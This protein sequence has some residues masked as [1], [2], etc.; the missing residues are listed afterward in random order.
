MIYL[1]HNSTTPLD[2]RVLDAMLPYLKGK[3]GNAASREHA[4][5]WDARD[6]VEDARGQVAALLNAKPNEIVFTSGATESIHIA[7][8]GLFLGPPSPGAPASHASPTS[9]GFDSSRPAPASPDRSG[10]LAS[11]ADCLGILA[12]AVEHEAVL[13]A[14][15][16]LARRGTRVEM[17]GVD[18]EGRIDP[19]AIATALSA[20]P[21]R[22]ICLMAANNETGVLTPLRACA[23]L[24]HAQGGLLFTDAA[25][26][27]GKI[28]LD[29]ER[30]GFD[31]AGVSAHKLNGPKG[32]GAL[33]VRNGGNGADV[34][35]G[36]NGGNGGT[37]SSLYPLLAAG[38]Q[39][40]GLR[41]GTANVP[42][43]VGFGEACRL[44][45][46]EMEARMEA[47]RALRDRL[48]TRIRERV[49]GAR[50]NGGGADRLG[51]TAN[52]VF[53]GVDARILIRD[54]HDVAVSTRSACSSGAS[55]PSHVLKAMGLADAD[56]YASVR[57]SLGADTTLHDIEYA[58]DKAAASYRKLTDPGAA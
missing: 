42:A 46:M 26:A 16:H 24:A 49:P 28:P 50:V 13:A 31:F 34:G 52:M 54:M 23:D 3:W 35:S 41:G 58:A 8:Y 43:I 15:G 22:L 40:G 45:G 47:L 11:P 20:R 9:P 33:Y 2:P 14:C 21:A 29:A 57:F 12:S 1:D 32:I 48:E 4:F 44:A 18:A 51:N 27:L 25:Q 39:E 5:G 30:D 53:P 19:A 38:G 7:L 37:D 36:G 10:I 17:L 55:G 56:A 6:A